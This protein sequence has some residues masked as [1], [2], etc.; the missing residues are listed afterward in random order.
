[1]NGP[2][3]K[4]MKI[5]NIKENSPIDGFTELELE[6]TNEEMNLLIETG[7]NTILKEQIER[8]E[9]EN[10]ICPAIPNAE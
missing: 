9:N 1:M 8:I 10:N 4:K 6:M 2:K 7:L 5:I 3:E